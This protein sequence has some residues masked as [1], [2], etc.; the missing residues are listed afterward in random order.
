[1][2][3]LFH[4]PLDPGCRKVRILLGEKRLDCALKTEKIWERRESFLKLSPAGE[5]PV[6]IEDD[7]TSIPGGG[8]IAEYLEEA[9][10]EPPLIGATPLDRAETRRLA[11]WFD[12]KFRR[13]VTKNLLEEKIMKRFLGL[14]QPNSA[15]IRAGHA[16]VHY[17]LDYIGWLCDRRRWLGGDDFSLADVAAA[18][19]LSAIDYLGDVPWEDHRGAKDWYARVKSRPSLR[20]ILADHIPGVAP[21]KHY[22]DLDF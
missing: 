7:G 15:A 21:P 18:A 1:M 3:T 22:A 20:S 2:R 8:V 17:H 13:E 16:N 6:L 19:H 9:Y 14:G 11:N 10:P 12:V 5:V 4:L